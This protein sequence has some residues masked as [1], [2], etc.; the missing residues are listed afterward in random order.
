VGCFT[1]FLVGEFEVEGLGFDVE[2]GMSW[3]VDL[4]TIKIV[5]LG[6]YFGP[7]LFIWMRRHISYI[8]YKFYYAMLL[9]QIKI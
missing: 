3:V 5:G 6:T 1:Y 4:T 8:V 7:F 2:P 9:F